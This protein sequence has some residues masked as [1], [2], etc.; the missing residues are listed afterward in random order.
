MTFLF[1]AQNTPTIDSD[2]AL[3]LVVVGLIGLCVYLL[4]TMIAYNR[5]HTSKMAILALNLVFGWSFVGWVIALIWALA[6]NGRNRSNVLFQVGYPPVA[7]QAYPAPPTYVQPPAFAHAPVQAPAFA[8]APIQP[9]AQHAYVPAVHNTI[10]GKK[11]AC[12]LCGSIVSAQAVFCPFC[13]AAIAPGTV[14]PIGP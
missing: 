11:G 7:P 4:P 5:N 13:R 1:L 8:P 14:R 6:D 3:G 10:G 12:P 2:E 9:P